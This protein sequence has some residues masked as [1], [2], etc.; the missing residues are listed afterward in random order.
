MGLCAAE[1]LVHHGR[2]L[3]ALGYGD[4]RPGRLRRLSG[5]RRD[6]GGLALC[7]SRLGRCSPRR[8]L[9][10]LVC[11]LFVLLAG[12]ARH[13]DKAGNRHS[14]AQLARELRLEHSAPPIDSPTDWEEV[15]G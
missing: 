1:R 13:G 8:R 14:K 3:R 5:D 4:H 11:G 6:L 9:R 12:A 15:A 7:D 10:S 2:E